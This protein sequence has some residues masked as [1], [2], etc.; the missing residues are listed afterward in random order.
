MKKERADFAT[1]TENGVVT[2]V[3]RSTILTPK[4]KF[5][6]GEVKWFDDSK[7]L[8]PNREVGITK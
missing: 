2:K 1:V 7:L 4:I 8:K 5:R 3:G 6:G